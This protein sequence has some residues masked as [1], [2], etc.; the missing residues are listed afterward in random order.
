MD[1][2]LLDLDAVF[3]A[4]EVCRRSGATDFEVGYLDDTVDARDARW[5]ARANYGG[6]RLLVEEQ[7]GA[8]IAATG[9]ARRV[10][11][12]GRCGCGLTIVTRDTVIDRARNDN[13]R[14]A[15]DRCLWERHGRHWI[16]GCV[17]YAAE[18]HRL[19]HDPKTPP[20]RLPPEARRV[21]PAPGSGDQ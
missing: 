10:L 15:T 13:L 9:L 2:A 17:D 4:V 16:P 12:G 3:A 8:D 20:R 6:D 14:P 5:W 21:V 1:R 7:P 11:D 18:V 19:E